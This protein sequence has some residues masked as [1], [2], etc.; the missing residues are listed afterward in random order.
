[1]CRQVRGER[2]GTG[3]LTTTSFR[4]IG[5][6]DGSGT[7]YDADTC[8]VTIFDGTGGGGSSLSGGTT[9]YVPLWSSATALGT[10]ALYQNGSGYIGLGSSSPVNALDIGTT[11]GIHI[12]SGVPISTSNAL[13]NNSGT[14]TWNGSP[15]ASGGALA[16]LSDVTLTSP[17][18]NN[19][20]QY[21]G[22]KW[23][24]VSPSTAMGTTTMV[25]NWPDAIMCNYSS[26]DWQLLYISDIA[27]AS[28]DVRYAAPP[29]GGQEAISFNNDGTYKATGTA[30][31]S[32]AASVYNGGTYN[33]VNKTITQLYASSQAFNFIG[34]SL[35]SAAAPAGGV[36]FNNGS[37]VLAADS[38]LFWDNTNKR[39]G[40]GSTSPATALDVNG[41]AK[42]RRSADRARA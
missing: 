41:T 7:L 38:N 31:I 29:I 25:P 32:G 4:L 6:R 36:Q 39:L 15:V 17:A 1:M 9:N 26:T 40:I 24:N 12:A 23:V 21:N 14:L 30:V 10:S 8:V 37:G 35:A 27:I 3:S 19:I 13:Y 20:L 16:S 33:C 28:S 11:G 18:N 2:S 22:T 5:I 42:A 34:S